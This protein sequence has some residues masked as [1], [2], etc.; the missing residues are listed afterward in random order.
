MEP[1]WSI[2]AVG[3]R[4]FSSKTGWWPCSR[5][6]D[7]RSLR[8][9]C[10]CG[11]CPPLY[12]CANVSL[13]FCDAALRTLPMLNSFPTPRIACKKSSMIC[14]ACFR[15][16]AA[17]VFERWSSRRRAM[18]IEKT[19]EREGFVFILPCFRRVFQ[20]RT[21]NKTLLDCSVHRTV[22]RLSQTSSNHPAA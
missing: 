10:H 17:F 11:K 18:M 7:L 5:M 2:G 14:C 3:P 15:M 9:W 16:A 12:F 1:F 6:R 19:N 4:C 22:T 21:T 20:R 8:R 13:K